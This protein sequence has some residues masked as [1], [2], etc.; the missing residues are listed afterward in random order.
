MDR[1]LKKQDREDQEKLID[2]SLTAAMHGIDW[3]PPEIESKEPR[4]GE[5]I[6]NQL[7]S[8]GI[9]PTRRIFV[10]KEEIERRKKVLNKGET[11]E[12]V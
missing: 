8:Q 11:N 12:Q 7:K 1:R 3:K 2:L 10:S 6:G 5:S 4:K 9:F